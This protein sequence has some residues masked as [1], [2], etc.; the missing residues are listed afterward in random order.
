MSEHTAT[1]EPH[2]DTPL[3]GPVVLWLTGYPGSGKT[4]LGDYLEHAQ[5]FVHVDGDAIMLSQVQEDKDLT[6]GIIKA[7]YSYWLQGRP[8]P[9]DCWVPYYTKLCSLITAARAANPKR[10][11][12]C[13]FST[14]PRLVRDFV[15]TQIP[16]VTFLLLKVDKDNVL[17]RLVER[18]THA[19][20]AFETD[21][22]V[23]TRKQCTSELSKSCPDLVAALAEDPMD[24][25]KVCRLQMATLLNGFELAGTPPV[26]YTQEADDSARAQP[27]TAATGATAATAAAAAPAVV[28]E[29]CTYT[30]DSSDVGRGPDGCGIARTVHRIVGLGAVRPFA[31]GVDGD[32]HVTVVED[33]TSP[34]LEI[35]G[36][37]GALGMRT[38]AET[39]AAAATAEVEALRAMAAS[40][41]RINY[42]RWERACAAAKQPL[43]PTTTEGADGAGD[44]SP[45]SGCSEAQGEGE[46]HVE[47]AE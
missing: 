39:A 24:W 9:E 4:W 41:S 10:H 46:R 13:T 6:A 26:P 17:D 45:V 22:D 40:I 27:Q 11:I 29:P 2:V 16:E 20:R 37:S 36:G 34:V 21:I 25:R 38:P 32:G 18:N 23:F 8:A 33:I 15:R 28:P 3:N 14:Y 44:G 7:F 30:L 5:Q 31:I 35:G 1:I 43:S 42:A 47:E 19:A 12:V